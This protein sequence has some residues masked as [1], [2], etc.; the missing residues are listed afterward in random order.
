M[1][2]KHLQQKSLSND[3]EQIAEGVFFYWQVWVAVALIFEWKL[4]KT[5]F[6]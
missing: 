5:I 6:I 4:I 2:G 3:R 1:K